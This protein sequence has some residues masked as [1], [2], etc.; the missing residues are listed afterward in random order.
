[1]LNKKERAKIKREI[2]K[3]LKEFEWESEWS[4]HSELADFIL[5]DAIK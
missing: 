1:M 2:K 3:I 5:N 4:T